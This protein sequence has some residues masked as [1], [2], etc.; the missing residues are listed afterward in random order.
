MII[1]RLN[2]VKFSRILLKQEAV[3]H[4]LT[5]QKDVVA[6]YVADSSGSG[7]VFMEEY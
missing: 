2:A 5:E 6:M 1:S 7:L 4:L 3:S